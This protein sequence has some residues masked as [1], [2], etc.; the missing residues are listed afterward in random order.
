ME[1]KFVY[2][3][4]AADAARTGYGPVHHA[5]DGDDPERRAF[6]GLDASDYADL[7]MSP[8]RGV[9]SAWF[10]GNCY[11]RAYDRGLLKAG[12]LNG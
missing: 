4:K 7:D 5:I 1:I 11:S 12:K 8:E 6:C 3:I 9:K 10:C 2:S